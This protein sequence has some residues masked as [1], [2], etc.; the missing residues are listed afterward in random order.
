MSVRSQ[1]EGFDASLTLAKKKDVI[2][3]GSGPAG[4][5]AAL[6][7]ARNGADVMIIERFGYLGGMMTGGGIGGIT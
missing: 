4:V 2:V 6:S 7:A 5:V 1:N 3:V